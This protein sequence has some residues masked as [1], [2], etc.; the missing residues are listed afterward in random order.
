MFCFFYR[1]FACNFEFSLLSFLKKYMRNL[2]CQVLK[3]RFQLFKFKYFTEIKILRF[4]HFLVPTKCSKLRIDDIKFKTL[5]Y[6]LRQSK[7]V[8]SQMIILVQHKRTSCLQTKSLLDSTWW[9]IKNIKRV[10]I[11]LQHSHNIC[12]IQIRY[13]LSH[14]LEKERVKGKFMLW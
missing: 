9:S 5:V 1:M 11:A 4:I 6:S 10:Y 2:R 12:C 7:E 13:V 3:D 8:L 14:L